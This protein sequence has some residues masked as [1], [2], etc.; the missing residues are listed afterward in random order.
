MKTLWV[1]KKEREAES[2][3]ALVRYSFPPSCPGIVI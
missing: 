2:E 3:S 1:N